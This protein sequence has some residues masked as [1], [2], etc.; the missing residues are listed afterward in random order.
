MAERRQPFR[1][2][3]PW[4]QR[5]TEQQTQSSRPTSVSRRASRPA[6]RAPSQPP[7]SQSQPPSKAE[8]QPSSASPSPSPATAINESPKETPSKPSVKPPTPSGAATKSPKETPSIPTLKP[9]TSSTPS[10]KF[11]TPSRAATESPKV[12]SSTAKGKRQISSHTATESTKETHSP[13]TTKP[14]T[15]SH[16]STESSKKTF[17]NPTFKPQMPS[18]PAIKPPKEISSAPTEET[19]SFPTTKPQTSSA[20]TSKP[21]TSSP[22]ATEFS[23]ETPFVPISKSQTPTPLANES[24]KETP[25]SQNSKLQTPS[26]FATESPKENQSLQFTKS[27]SATP[28][29]TSSPSTNIAVKPPSPTSTATNSTKVTQLP[30]TGKTQSPSSITSESPEAIS[31]PTSSTPTNAIVKPRSPSLA[32][33]EASKATS[34]S[35]SSPSVETVVAKP[36]SP[37]VVVGKSQVSSKPT[38]PPQVRPHR[39][40]TSV[41]SSPSST[42]SESS[43]VSALP[44]STP[45][46][47]IVK[48]QSP[49]FATMEASKA[50]SSPFAEIDVTKPPSPS[51]AVG[52]SQISSKP[53]S[54]P[55]VRPHG[56]LT[57]VLSSPSKRDSKSGATSPSQSRVTFE[58]QLELGRSFQSQSPTS[59]HAWMDNLGVSSPISKATQQKAKDDIVSQSPSSPEKP[60][61]RAQVQSSNHEQELEKEVA[62]MVSLRGAESKEKITSETK[63]IKTSQD[64]LAARELKEVPMPL[65]T[66]MSL[67]EEANKVDVPPQKSDLKLQPE[68]EKHNVTFQALEGQQKREVSDRTKTIATT[69]YIGNDAEIAKSSHPI[70]GNTNNSFQKPVLTIEEE[71]SLHK[72]II[73]DISK[74]VKKLTTRTQVDEKPVIVVTLTGENK[75]AAMHMSSESTKKE[76]S[77]HIHRSYKTNLEKSPKNENTTDGETSSGE[78]HIDRMIREAHSPKAYVNSNAQSVN[79][80]IVF[81]ASIEEKNPGVQLTYSQYTTDEVKQLKL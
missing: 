56:G 9:Q 42:T 12:T 17:S 10:P 7:P 39:G 5:S 64:A 36:S 46:N 75:G 76:E 23:K 40:L 3:L 73:E 47:A 72:N 8:A 61:V 55:Q 69:T 68:L 48:A 27:T 31:L 6:G 37:S 78:R 33:I 52:K 14:Q 80:S 58:S 21:Q 24:Q 19:Q 66:T 41:L 53:T 43:E 11:K 1:F 38:S 57:S 13:R 29:S 81:N 32:T 35:T 77:I 51:L 71:V 59:Q 49:S 34:Q 18:R 44:T 79:N 28:Q 62:F 50:T 2:R 25:S 54:P 30:T 4:S 45:A 26:Q 16:A 65:E 60:Q 74:L 70:R 20:P 15:P 22:V 63:R 67:S